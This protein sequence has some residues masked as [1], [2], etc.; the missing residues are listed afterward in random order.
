MVCTAARDGGPDAPGWAARRTAGS[1]PE[2]LLRGDVGLA[3]AQGSGP[4][5][6]PLGERGHRPAVLGE[7]QAEQE[8]AQGG[9]PPG[10]AAPDRTSLL[11]PK[12]WLSE[13]PTAQIQAS[14]PA[15]FLHVSTQTWAPAAR[16]ACLVQP[17]AL[18]RA[19]PLLGE[20]SPLC[21]AYPHPP[22]PRV[23]AP[24]PAA[25]TS[26][27]SGPILSTRAT[28]SVRLAHRLRGAAACADRTRTSPSPSMHAK[29]QGRRDAGEGHRSTT[30]F[31]RVSLC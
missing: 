2:R 7:A 30:E 11:P 19:V 18:V 4:A 3:P 23:P 24:V 26:G 1:W 13:S 17:P 10:T 12:I 21:G 15:S 8:L 9:A 28:H 27:S 14:R 16:T 6:G 31:L 25:A 20:P 5:S 29:V 22:L